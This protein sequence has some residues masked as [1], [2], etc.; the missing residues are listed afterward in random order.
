[1][2]AVPL[3]A[4]AA[5]LLLAVALVAGPVPGETAGMRVV[6][7]NLLHGGPSSGLTGEDGHLDDRLAIVAR[8]LRA[9]A[10]DI[11]GLQESSISRRRHVA[12]RLASDLGLGAYIIAAGGLLA[13]IAGFIGTRPKILA[14]GTPVSA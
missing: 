5:G 7:F 4:L 3:P 11:V 2:G 10:V 14:T 1:M 9:L 6:T 8:E 12:A 13:L